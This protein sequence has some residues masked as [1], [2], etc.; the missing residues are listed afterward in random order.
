MEHCAFHPMRLTPGIEAWP[1]PVR[2][3]VRQRVNHVRVLETSSTCA[4]P[5]LQA[6]RE[7]ALSTVI[8]VISITYLHFKAAGM[9]EYPSGKQR[10]ASPE[11]AFRKLEKNSKIR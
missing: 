8:A 6:C 10:S 11:Q 4:S 1:S 7:R 2:G 3:V 9:P 5:S